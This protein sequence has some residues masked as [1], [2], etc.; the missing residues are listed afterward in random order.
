MA[1]LLL[2]LMALLPQWTPDGVAVAAVF[3]FGTVRYTGW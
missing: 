3:V 1:L 2:L